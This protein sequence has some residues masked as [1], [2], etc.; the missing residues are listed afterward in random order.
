MSTFDSIKSKIQ[1]AVSEVQ[2]KA[3]T[4]FAEVQDKATAALAEAQEKANE[5][6]GN[7]KELA[8]T[9][10]TKAEEEFANVKTQATEFATKAVDASKTKF[11]EAEVKLNEVVG[12]AKTELDQVKQKMSSKDTPPEA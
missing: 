9:A 12:K 5:A 6:L 3:T 1:T 11:A 8:E 4:A 7:A 2:E 10:K